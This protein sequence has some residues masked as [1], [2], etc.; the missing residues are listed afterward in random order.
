MIENGKCVS[1]NLRWLSK[2]HNPY[3]VKRLGYHIND[4]FFVTRERDDKQVTQNS[5]VSLVATIM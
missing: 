1:Q 4:I 3:V 5:G 2:G